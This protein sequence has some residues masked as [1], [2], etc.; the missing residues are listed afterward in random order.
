MWQRGLLSILL[1]VL[2]TGTATPKDARGIV[3]DVA[4]TIGAASLKTI[5]YSGSGYTYFSGQRHEPGGA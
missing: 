1:L 2:F 4:R 3:A 5:Q